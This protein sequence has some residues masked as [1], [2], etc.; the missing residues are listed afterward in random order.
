MSSGKHV[1]LSSE[2]DARWFEL[3]R[4]AAPNGKTRTEF[5][6]MVRAEMPQMYQGDIK[7]AKNA[8]S[9]K[10]SQA[11]AAFIKAGMAAVESRKIAAG[12]EQY[13][14]ACKAIG[15][16]CDSL[17]PEF[18]RGRAGG[19][20]ASKHADVIDGLLDGLDDTEDSEETSA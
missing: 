20:G 7:D 16:K 10:I 6:E 19:G 18:K 13:K 8:V 9:S 12:S 4:Q 14:K 5:V 11:R 1:V 15:D 2:Q 3:L 17:Y